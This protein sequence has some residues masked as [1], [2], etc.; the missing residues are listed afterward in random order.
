MSNPCV[1]ITPQG[2]YRFDPVEINA[3]EYLDS[4]SAAVSVKQAF[5]NV[6]NFGEF[7]QVVACVDAS[8]AASNCRGFIGC[9]PVM[10]FTTEGIAG[11]DD[12]IIYPRFGVRVGEGIQT[13]WTFDPAIAWPSNAYSTRIL[14]GCTEMRRAGLWLAVV[15]DDH[16]GVYKLPMSN[17]FGQGLLCMEVPGA[18]RGESLQQM[19]EKLLSAF[20][21]SSFSADMPP[22]QT[23]AR[24]VFR[25]RYE[26]GVMV[27]QPAMCTPWDLERVSPN[28]T[29]GG[30]LVTEA[31]RKWGVLPNEVAS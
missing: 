13:S 16:R 9:L 3:K 26:N 25:Y 6:G 29:E 31:L 11:N 15:H 8:Q 24:S 2:I 12:G 5:L 14:L 7:V 28:G 1:L 27:Q 18:V 30:I 17:M 10:K 21:A 22:D 4:L 23:E 19:A 20:I